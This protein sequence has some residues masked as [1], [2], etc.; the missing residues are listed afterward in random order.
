M[1]S[2]PPHLEHP[3]SLNKIEK[4]RRQ[5]EIRAA[6]ALAAKQ[7]AR[8]TQTSADR[9]YA[10]R[11]QEEY[12]IDGT[13]LTA[14]IA[15]IDAAHRRA[16]AEREEA[17]RAEAERQRVSRMR[18]LSP[19]QVR[20]MEREAE[21]ERQRQYAQQ[22][23]DSIDEAV[24]AILQHQRSRFLHGALDPVH[25]TLSD[26]EPMPATE[27]ELRSIIQRAVR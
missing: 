25:R 21:D 16:Q 24:A 3:K 11:L 20:I 4:V 2:T 22:M 8:E 7:R 19:A 12:S 1:S 5:Q 10:L 9:E 15:A 18:S 23:Q 27:G 6:I 14:Q 13:E 26:G 17:E